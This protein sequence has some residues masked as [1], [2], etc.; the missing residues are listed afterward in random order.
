MLPIVRGWW[1]LLEL[2]PDGGTIAY[3]RYCEF[4]GWMSY[5][6]YFLNNSTYYSADDGNTIKGEFETDG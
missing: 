3:V 2:D 6:P 5:A 1:D 4:Y